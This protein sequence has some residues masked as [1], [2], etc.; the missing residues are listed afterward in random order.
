MDDQV[1]GWDLVLETWSQVS[2]SNAHSSGGFWTNESITA[3]AKGPGGRLG[4]RVAGPL[5]LRLQVLAAGKDTLESGMANTAAHAGLDSASPGGRHV[6][7]PPRGPRRPGDGRRSPVARKLSARRQY[8]P[9]D[10]KTPTSSSVTA[11]RPSSSK[12]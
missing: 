7:V 2:G 3:R 6:V 11:I 10:Q 4:T 8:A 12:R 1:R 5:G 9:I